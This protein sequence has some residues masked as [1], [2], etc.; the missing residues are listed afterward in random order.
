MSVTHVVGA[1]TSEDILGVILRTQDVMDPR[2]ALFISIDPVAGFLDDVGAKVLFVSADEDLSVDVCGVPTN[3][4]TLGAGSA[5]Y[6]VR[7][8][9]CSDGLIS[10]LIEVLRSRY[11][12]VVVFHGPLFRR[13]VFHDVGGHATFVML[14]PSH[15]SKVSAHTKQV[16]CWINSIATSCSDDLRIGLWFAHTDV[17]YGEAQA[18]YDSFDGRIDLYDQGRPPMFDAPRDRVKAPADLHV[19]KIADAVCEVVSTTQQSVGAPSTFYEVRVEAEGDLNEEVLWEVMLLL[20]SRYDNRYTF[21]VT[22]DEGRV[23]VIMELD[24]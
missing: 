20:R 13:D 15:N 17:R 10:H 23:R 16:V 11:E 9:R 18:L 24:E 6:W 7:A 1:L 5:N 14:P 22:L 19:V 8:E 3:V 2:K 4:V 12:V 21:R